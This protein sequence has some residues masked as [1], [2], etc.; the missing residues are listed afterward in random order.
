MTE[1]LNQHPGLPVPTAND[2]LFLNDLPDWNNNAWIHKPSNK[3]SLYADG[4]IEG[5]RKL[6]DKCLNEQQGHDTLVFPI[7]F[8]YRHY[9][10]LRLKE[11]IIGLN[12]LNDKGETLSQTHNVVNLW[13]DFEKKYSIISTDRSDEFKQTERLIK[14]FSS[15]DP[16]SMAFR[17]PIDTKGNNSLSINLVNLRNFANVMDKIHIFLNAL[18]WQVDYYVELSDDMKHEKEFYYQDFLENYNEDY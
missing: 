6:V 14:E 1:D 13:N 4:Y 8:L 10:E 3:F 11:L 7:I 9:I 18:S 17:Y 5:A 15:I 2:K 12:Y 16:K